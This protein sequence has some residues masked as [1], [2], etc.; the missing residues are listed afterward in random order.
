MKCWPLLVWNDGS[1]H[2]RMGSTLLL[3]L[4]RLLSFSDI[5]RH[6][7]RCHHSPP[8]ATVVSWSLV[9]EQPWVSMSRLCTRQHAHT[10][11]SFTADRG[12]NRANNSQSPACSMASY[13]LSAQL[14]LHFHGWWEAGSL[15]WQAIAKLR[16]LLQHHPCKCNRCAYT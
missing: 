16:W 13:E 3:G 1:K 12:T 2:M 5:L 10:S 15:P 9:K 6:C 4:G 7:W 11:Q 14:L 8:T